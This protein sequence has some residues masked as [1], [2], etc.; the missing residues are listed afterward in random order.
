MGQVQPVV[1]VG[2][3]PTMTSWNPCSVASF[4][5]QLTNISKKFLSKYGFV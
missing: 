5:N 2:S 4:L 1:P 3:M